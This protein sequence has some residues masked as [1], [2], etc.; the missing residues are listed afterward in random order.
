MRRTLYLAGDGGALFTTVYVAAETL[1]LLR[2][3]LGLEAAESW[4]RQVD[5]SSRLRWESIS[6]ARADKAR[7]LFIRYHD[8]DLSFTDC[9]SF[10][11]MRELKLREA[12]TTDRHFA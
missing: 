6:H 7:S 1:T 3:R 8:K 4:L 11:V 12:L 9:A 2:M 10:V 5:G